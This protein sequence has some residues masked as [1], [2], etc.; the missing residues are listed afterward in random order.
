ME[1]IKRQLVLQ[2][3]SIVAALKLLAE[4]RSRSLPSSSMDRNSSLDRSSLQEQD[5]GLNSLEVNSKV[6]NIY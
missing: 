5:R 3:G 6:E 1:Q 4:S 2:R